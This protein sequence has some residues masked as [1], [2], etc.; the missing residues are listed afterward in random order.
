MKKLGFSCI[1]I[2]SGKESLILRTLLQELFLEAIDA[3]A[4]PDSDIDQCCETLAQLIVYQREKS[5]A[6]KFF[7]HDQKYRECSVPRIP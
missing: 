5:L 1:Y 6:K 2:L 4:S 7:H 3:G